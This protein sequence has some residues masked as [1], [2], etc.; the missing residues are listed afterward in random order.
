M[1][2]ENL[3][4]INCNIIKVIYSLCES[5]KGQRPHRGSLEVK[6]KDSF[7]AQL[8]QAMKQDSQ[9]KYKNKQKKK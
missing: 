1:L 7:M 6:K 3:N 2:K 5:Q 9:F 8:A 4:Q